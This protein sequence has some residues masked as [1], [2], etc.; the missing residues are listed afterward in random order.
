MALETAEF[1]RRFLLHVLPQGFVR[2]LYYGFL[3]NCCRTEKLA[4]CRRPLSEGKPEPASGDATPQDDL[5]HG[6]TIVRTICPHCGNGN[7]TTSLCSSVFV[8]ALC[9]G[10]RHYA[11][12]A[13]R[14]QQHIAVFAPMP[15][16]SVRIAINEKPGFLNNIRAPIRR[17]WKSV[18]SIGNPLCS[19]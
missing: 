19:R 11:V 16:A 5:Q 10:V 8:C 4:L 14:G 3:A 6:S 18:S 17:S 1:A 12:N 7:G 2:A 9:D 15:S 13:N